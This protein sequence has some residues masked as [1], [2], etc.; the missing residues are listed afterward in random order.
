MGN[1]EISITDTGVGL[2]RLQQD[3][4]FQSGVQFNVN[5]LQAGGGSGLGLFISRGITKQHHGEL[6]VSSP[7][8]GQG[9]TFTCVLPLYEIPKVDEKPSH[10]EAE[11]SAFSR[12]DSSILDDVSVRTMTEASASFV[13]HEARD[14]TCVQQK[15]TETSIPQDLT[16]V[17]E[18]ES[19]SLRILV[20]D[21]VMSNRKL[22]VRLVKKHG[23]DVDDAN[24]GHAAV[25]KVA[26]ALSEGR[27]YDAILMDHEMPILKGPEATKK[28]RGMGSDSCVIGITGNVLAEDVNHFLSCGA[29]HVLPK[30]VNFKK[31]EDLFVEHGVY[32]L[33]SLKKV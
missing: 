24:D 21:D 17:P 13:P 19:G 28:I 9:S 4:M 27:G 30:P 12:V 15:G 3:S 1:L 32:A 11:P 6:K 33:H 2:S 5:E 31:V 14:V 16:E 25:E 10:L 29:N 20:V 18:A 7:G 26:L 8:I 22:L 23:H